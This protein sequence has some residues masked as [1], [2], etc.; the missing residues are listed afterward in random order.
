[1]NSLVTKVTNLA[2]HMS[3]I[4]NLLQ[5]DLHLS[6]QTSYRRLT[7]CSV[8]WHWQ[9]RVLGPL[10]KLCDSEPD[11]GPALKLASHQSLPPAPASHRICTGHVSIIPICSQTQN[12]SSESWQWRCHGFK[13]W[14]VCSQQV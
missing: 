11:E 13:S 6:F 8:C 14:M 2:R 4:I 3:N 5:T 7:S 9:P 1:M 10:V 12:A